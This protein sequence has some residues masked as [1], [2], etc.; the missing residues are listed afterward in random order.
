[1]LKQQGIQTAKGVY[2]SFRRGQQCILGFG[3]GKPGVGK[4]ITI[5]TLGLGG[6][7]EELLKNI[8]HI[9]GGDYRY[10]P[11]PDELVDMMTEIA[12]NI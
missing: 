4:G 10:S 2:A 3:T 12:G 7:K 5:F 8:A 1:M 9:T 6:V 11:T